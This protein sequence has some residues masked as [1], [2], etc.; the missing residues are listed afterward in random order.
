VSDVGCT[1]GNIHIG[2]CDIHFAFLGYLYF[3]RVRFG[4]IK[5]SADPHGQHKVGS[6]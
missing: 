4:K 2:K 1:G 5:P 3:S 6:A